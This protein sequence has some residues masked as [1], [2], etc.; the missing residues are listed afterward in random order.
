MEWSVVSKKQTFISLNVEGSDVSLVSLIKWVGFTNRGELHNGRVGILG[1]GM[2]LQQTTGGWLGTT[3]NG[4]LVIL[5]TSKSH[6]ASRVDNNLSWL[7]SKEVSLVESWVNW[8]CTILNWSWFKL[9]GSF[10]FDNGIIKV[11][12]AWWQGMN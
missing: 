10:T 9:N 5:D 11:R 2:S 6:L 3:N 8:S 12:R 4:Q 7:L 1:V